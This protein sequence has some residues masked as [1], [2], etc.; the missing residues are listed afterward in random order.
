VEVLRKIWTSI[1]VRRIQGFW[2]DNFGIT[3]GQR[4]FLKGR[5]TDT[6]KVQM[7]QALETGKE[8]KT[9]CT[10]RRGI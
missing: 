1:F 9:L 10:Y 3:E 5:G 4:G 8:F 6:S 2:G 7:I